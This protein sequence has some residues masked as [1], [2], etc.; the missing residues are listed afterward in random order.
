LFRWLPN[1]ASNEAEKW[2]EVDLGEAVS[3]S[4]VRVWQDR[5]I[6]SYKILGKL[7]TEASWAVLAEATANKATVN[8]HKT[9][10]KVVSRVRLVS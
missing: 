2:I 7:E 6:E 8:E 10:D 3:L 4:A 9:T 5:P 1:P